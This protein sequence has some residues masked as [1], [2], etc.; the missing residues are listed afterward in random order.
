M[1]KKDILCPDCAIEYISAKRNKDFGKCIS[2]QRREVRAKTT[3]TPYIKYKD[4]SEEEKVRLARQ[5]EIKSKSAKSTRIANKKS[6]KEVTATTNKTKKIEKRAPGRPQIYTPE[7]IEQM[8]TIANDTITPAELLDMLKSLYPDKNF[9]IGNIHNI[10]LRNDIPHSSRRGKRINIVKTDI[11][12]ESVVDD[13]IDLDEDIIDDL[14]PIFNVNQLS[15]VESVEDVTANKDVQLSQTSSEPIDCSTMKGKHQMNDI[16]E[17][18]A[19]VKREIDEVLNKKFDSLGC[20]ID[21]D[22]T[23]DDYIKALEIVLYLKDNIDTITENRRNQQNIMNAYQSDII[24]EFENVIA[25]EGDTYLSDKMYIL[26]QYRRYY[27]TD[28]T[29]V[30]YMKPLISTIDRDSLEKTID[31]LKRNKTFVDHPMFTP[32]IDTTMIDKYEWAQPLKPTSTKAKISVVNYN[33]NGFNQT[34]S[35][36]GRPVT[37]VG[38]SANL[39]PTEQLNS[40]MRK[41]LK[42]FRVSCRISGGG[43]GVFQNWYRDYECKNSKIALSYATNTLN[44]LAS[45]KKGM[46]WT[47]LDVVELNVDQN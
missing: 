32:L 14:E 43:Y 23:T 45:N 17:R 30:G 15:D 24:H 7:I 38:V 11:K 16:P 4:L 19:P 28:Y 9:T 37:R 20:N 5:R 3:G 10:I 44:Q 22:Y 12:P 8:K 21:T 2:C 26:R 42:I 6:K 29:N 25:D 46:V 31:R 41:A 18:F 1:E 40:K 35:N 39:P 34:N 27:K 36:N 47:D 33:P 13:T